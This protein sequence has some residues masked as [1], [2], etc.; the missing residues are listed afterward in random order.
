MRTI[1]AGV[2]MSHDLVPL[3]Q[4][5]PL[6]VESVADIVRE[7]LEALKPKTREAY[8]GDLLDFAKSI[9]AA[10]PGEAA[11]LLVGL[12]HGDANLA[13][14]RYRTTLEKRLQA[15]ATINRKLSAL[16]WVVKVARRAGRV[17]WS[18]DVQGAKVTPYRDTSGPPEP[19]R[20]RL[21]KSALL[22]TRTP[23]GKRD[24]ALIML[25]FN[26]MLRRAEAIALDLADLDL[27]RCKVHVV[28]K[29]KLD[30]E[31]LTIPTQARDA[32][33]DWLG[34]RGDEPGPVFVRLDPGQSSVY[35]RLTLCSVNRLLGRLSKQ[36]GLTRK[37]RPHGL[38]HAGITLM[39]N[40]TQGN[41]RLVRRASRH[42]K[43]ET[44]D[45]YDDNRRDDAGELVQR[46]ADAADDSALTHRP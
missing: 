12:A 7:S 24:Y 3:P 44:V 14:F 42:K 2:P 17:A 31:W 10:G 30:P 18:L 23:I 1:R 33:R 45:L 4:A 43:M 22:R 34:V 29:G 32:L 46:A 35:E 19:E 8:A 28:G 39:L 6:R 25:L 27:E 11:E 36:A 5:V 41:T 38:R 26:P 13:A 16:R 40:I 15:P 20:V 37:V 21:M 9:G